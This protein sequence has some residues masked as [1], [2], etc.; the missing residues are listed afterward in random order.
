M[1]ALM[2]RWP[3]SYAETSGFEFE[4]MRNIFLS[5]YEVRELFWEFWILGRLSRYTRIT[6]VWL[7][8]PDP[9]ARCQTPVPGAKNQCQ[10]PRTQSLPLLKVNTLLRPQHHRFLCSSV[11]NTCLTSSWW[12]PGGVSTTGGVDNNSIS[13]L[14]SQSSDPS[15]SYITILPLLVFLFFHKCL[16]FQFHNLFCTCVG[17]VPWLCFRVVI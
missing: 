10:V 7:R 9:S 14:L 2:K 3:R 4:A 6:E 15:V 13:C 8:V 17:C 11:A 1:L 5:R 16:F 12:W